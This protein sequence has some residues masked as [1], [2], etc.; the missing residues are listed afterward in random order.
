VSVFLGIALFLLEHEA[1]V[2]AALAKIVRRTA[3]ESARLHM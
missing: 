1:D 2:N 3:L